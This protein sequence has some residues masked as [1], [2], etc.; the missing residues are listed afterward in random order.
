[1]V[2]SEIKK[3]KEN[4]FE[5]L[6]NLL[7]LSPNYKFHKIEFNESMEKFNILKEAIYYI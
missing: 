3:I 1:M 7:W 4:S 6:W 5:K 2:D